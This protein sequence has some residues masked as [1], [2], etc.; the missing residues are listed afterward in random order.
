MRE[1]WSHRLAGGIVIGVLLAGAVLYVVPVWWGLPSYTGWAVDEAIPLRVLTPE[2]WSDKYPPLH[3][4]ALTLLF[5]IWDLVSSSSGLE[6]YT[7]LFVLGRV[8]SVVMALATVFLVYRIGRQL[9]G[10]RPALLGAA[11]F[12]VVPSF[13]YYSKTANLEAPYLLW[14]AVS[15]HFYLKILRRQRLRDYVLFGI[16]AALAVGTKDQAFALFIAV[17]VILL[18]ALAVRSEGGD[19]A[20]R[21][22]AAAVDRR[23]WLG[24][25]CSAVVLLLIHN[26]LFD[27]S[28]F[29]ARIA[30]LTRAPGA[31][32]VY[33]PTFVGQLELVGLS[34]RQL[35]FLLGLPLTLAALVGLGVAVRRPRRSWRILSFVPIALGYYLG[36]VAPIGYNYPRFLVPV[37]LLAAPFCGRGLELL[38][39]LRR[40]PRWVPTSLTALLLGLALARGIAVDLLLL[41]DS[42]YAVER[43]L[44][45]AGEEGRD[46]GY[47][48]RKL[49]P[50]GVQALEWGQLV[51][52]P[53]RHL[54]QT[55]PA[56]IVAVLGERLEQPEERALRR[57]ESGQLGYDLALRQARPKAA[58][59]LDPFGV[60]SNLDRV[61][62]EVLV[63]RR[64]PRACLDDR[65]VTEEVAAAA[66]GRPTDRAALVEAILDHDLENRLVYASADVVG[67]NL[68][69]GRWTH[70]T[71]PAAVAIRNTTAEALVP[72]LE[73]GCLAQPDVF[74][75]TVRIDDG[76]EPAEYTFRRRGRIRVTAASV[77][78]GEQRLL[79]VS[80]DKS[81]QARGEN[82]T[83][84]VSVLRVELRRPTEAAVSEPRR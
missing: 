28:G 45:E 22:G 42:R 46:A 76:V 11:S 40:I 67:V 17:P 80:S 32:R 54:T 47:G 9:M 77:P 68:Q 82:R 53:C 83:L 7:E 55:R 79:V 72:W 71:Q 64:A 13:V 50:R 24:G 39:S 33:P 35:V 73:I 29:F 57:L 74:P 84:G 27:A 19:W 23:L 18:G 30:F 65:S 44:R 49:M 38:W 10:R 15:V 8:L 43:W 1:D 48:S 41:G 61:S 59:L 78:P 6:H 21:L 56:H 69:F 66:A 81:W 58:A 37:A 51:G 36:F 25:V 60:E 2:T 5:R 75:V 20:Q 52:E 16:A 26:V 34:L 12:A 70:G 63:L 62:P 31:Y 3:R 4:Y 14:F